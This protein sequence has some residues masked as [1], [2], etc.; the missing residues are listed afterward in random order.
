MNLSNIP[1]GYKKTELG[2]IPKDWKV[3]NFCEVADNFTGLTYAPE[4]D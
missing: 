2:I 4:N 1:Q 3:V